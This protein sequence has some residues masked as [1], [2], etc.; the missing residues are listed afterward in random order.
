VDF[1]ILVAF[2]TPVE[3]PQSFSNPNL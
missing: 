2:I 1:P 3:T